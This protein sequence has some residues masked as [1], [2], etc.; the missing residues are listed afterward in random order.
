MSNT[1]PW[2][3]TLKPST[4]LLCGKYCSKHLFTTSINQPSPVSNGHRNQWGYKD[5][6]TNTQND[7]KNDKCCKVAEVWEWHYSV[8]KCIG[9]IWRLF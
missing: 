6:Q 7:F 1:V 9:I 8:G 2:I 4:Y 5:T 3:W